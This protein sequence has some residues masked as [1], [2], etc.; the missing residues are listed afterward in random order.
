ML[1]RIQG[2]TG[3]NIFSG[4]LAH[5][6]W[7]LSLSLSFLHGSYAAVYMCQSSTSSLLW[8]T[9]SPWP[10]LKISSCSLFCV[11]S[12]TL[13]PGA[14]CH[15]NYLLGCL[16]RRDIYSNK[17]PGNWFHS[18]ACF[19]M[20]LLWRGDDVHKIGP[21]WDEACVEYIS[22]FMGP[23]WQER[24]VLTSTSVTCDGS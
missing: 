12:V 8:P 15:M 16:C 14:Y 17:K 4:M 18:F 10:S 7:P 3:Y 24:K 22:D 21:A 13:W 20:T 5:S 1:H 19:A 2:Q 23:I 9:L 6:E 11:C